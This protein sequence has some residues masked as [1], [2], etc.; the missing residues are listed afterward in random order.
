PPGAHV[1]DWGLGTGDWGLGTDPIGSIP[2]YPISNIH[3]PILPR[4][5]VR[6][7]IEMTLDAISSDGAA[8]GRHPQSGKVVFVADA[9][10]GE[11]VEVEIVAES[12]RWMRGRLH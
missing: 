3:Y 11:R 10:P 6:F 1:G 7:V 8:V 9:I 2:Q 4:K 12:A 5:E